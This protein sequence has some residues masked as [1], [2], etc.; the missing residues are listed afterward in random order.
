MGHVAVTSGEPVVWAL[1]YEC[2]RCAMATRMNGVMACLTE[3][4]GSGQALLL[5]AMLLDVF[6]RAIF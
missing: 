3:S 6:L 1:R 5:P 2:L 4:A